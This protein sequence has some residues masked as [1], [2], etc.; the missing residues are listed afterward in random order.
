MLLVILQNRSC[1]L[2]SLSGGEQFDFLQPFE[3]SD[4]LVKLQ[5][6]EKVSDDVPLKGENDH[7]AGM[8]F[9][10]LLIRTLSFFF[11]KSR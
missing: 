10:L 11:L 5:S 7:S 9:W 1:D 8:N 3:R 6:S 2:P 4:S